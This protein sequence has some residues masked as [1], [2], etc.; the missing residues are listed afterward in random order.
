MRNI[1]LIISLAILSL[2]FVSSSSYAITGVCSNC[3]TMH[4]SQNG[5]GEVTTF[6]SGVRTE[7]GTTPQDYLLK[8]SCLGCHSGSTGQTNTF[9]APIVIHTTAPSGQGGNYTL[10][11][12]DFYWVATGLGATDARGHNV[13][14]VA[15]ADG[16][17]TTP[18]G[19]D[20]GATSGFTYGQ[21]GAGSWPSGTQV[22]CA[23]TYGC[24][25]Q[26][27]STGITGAH[28]GNTDGTATQSDGTNG[29]TTVGSSYRFLGGIYGLEDS[30]WNYGEDD[31]THNEYFGV[32]SPA[33]RD[34]SNST[35]GDK[36]TISFLCAQCHGYFHSRIDDTTGGA[37]PWRRHPTDIALP[38]T[39]EYNS[40]N[41]DNS[42][43]YSLE[44]PVARA[45]VPSASSAT[46][47]PGTDIVM[48]LSCHRAHG[49][50][51]DDLLRW[52]YSTIQAGTGTTDNGCF[53]CHTGKNAD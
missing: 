24:H 14:G 8:G 53:I 18:P 37:S 25:G 10:A 3:H 51:Q 49:S 41:P 52:D 6:A 28:H 46:V 1:L 33:S 11:G 32:D 26:H 27:S 43:A 12:G 17:L 39:G 22:T 4:N 38:S 40:Y 48:C 36:T 9:G 34:L 45:S 44:A 50:P 35:Y 15:A 5:A 2:V 19:W 21:I 31:S 42:N 13:S 23:G 20:A 7:L 16:Q 47:T 29:G 30:N